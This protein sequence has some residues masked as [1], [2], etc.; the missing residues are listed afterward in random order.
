[1]R[2]EYLY[3]KKI[4][5]SPIKLDQTKN[6]Q[7]RFRIPFDYPIK[8]FFYYIQ[9]Q[10]I[11]DA[12]QYYNFTH[13]FIL[14]RLDMSIRNKIKY[15]EQ[16]IKNNSYSNQIFK[17]Y[18]KLCKMRDLKLKT[19]NKLLSDNL[20]QTDLSI[21][22]LNLSLNDTSIIESYIDAYYDEIYQTK[23]IVQSQLYLNSICRFNTSDIL[24]NK[25]IPYQS[26]TGMIPGLQIFTFSLHPLEY[27]P[28]GYCNFSTLKPELQLTINDDIVISDDNDII[29]SY[30]I[31]RSY[32]IIRFMSGISG[33]AW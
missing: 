26:Y 31:G 23:T 19:L 32:N 8:D 30:I 10:S 33:I 6:L 21:L 2:H 3:E 20:V 16:Q 5:N 9:L 25:L 13:N 24:T 14:P 28:S 4:Y 7:N 15:I 22:Y 27:Q 18:L 1:M 12:K 29:R 17:L 11:I